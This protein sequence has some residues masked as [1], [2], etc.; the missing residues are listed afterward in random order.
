[1]SVSSAFNYS[2]YKVSN[3]F[4]NIIYLTFLKLV[5]IGIKSSSLTKFSS[6]LIANLLAFSVF[7]TSHLKAASKSG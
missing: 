4:D 7:S 6:G 2:E 1:M 3:F 5:S